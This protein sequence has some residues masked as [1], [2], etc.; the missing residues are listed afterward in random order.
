MVVH[1]RQ[2]FD[3]RY[4]PGGQNRSMVANAIPLSWKISPSLMPTGILMLQATC[5]SVRSKTPEAIRIFFAA[6]GISASTYDD[7]LIRLAMPRHR[8]TQGDMDLLV[9]T[10][11]QCGFD[12]V[13]E[14]G[15]LRVA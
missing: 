13:I 3:E 5:P 7:G 6:M 11:R 9:W 10:L 4:V 1:Y 15:E 14:P 2:K 8:L 12:E